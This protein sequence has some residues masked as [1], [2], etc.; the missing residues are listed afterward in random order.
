MET[1]VQSSCVTCDFRPDRFFCDMPAESLKAFDKIKSLALCRRNTVLFAEGRPVCGI[2]I[3]CD[4][5]AR[6]SICSDIGRRLTLRVAGP[7]EVLGLGAA[8]S[9]TPYEI[10]AELLDNSQVVFVRRKDLTKFLREHREVCL[11]VVHMLSQDLRGAYERVR[12]H[13][14][15]RLSMMD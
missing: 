1:T 6:L 9:N 5:R 11:Q 10:T 8:L 4:G 2:Y 7:G 3:L 14:H 13:F 12:S 15:G